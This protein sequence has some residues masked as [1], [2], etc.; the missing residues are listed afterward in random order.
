M[1]LNKWKPLL[2]VIFITGLVLYGSF[3]TEAAD[4]KSGVSVYNDNVGVKVL[5]TS[6]ELGYSFYINSNKRYGKENYSYFSFGLRY[7]LEDNYR[8]SPFITGEFHSFNNEFFYKIGGG[9]RFEN[10]IIEGGYRNYGSNKV[11]LGLSFDYSWQ[12]GNTYG[13]IKFQ[14]D[15]RN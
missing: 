9:Y 8:V 15:S 14:K 7:Y 12:E 2:L 6:S 5:E 13:H 10:L 4:L 3:N 1:Y 11:Y